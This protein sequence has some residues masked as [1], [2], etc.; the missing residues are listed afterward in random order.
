MPHWGQQSGDW[1]LF[2]RTLTASQIS[3]SPGHPSESAEQAE[4]ASQPIECTHLVQAEWERAGIPRSLV[5]ME[6]CVC[7]DELE[8]QA[9]SGRQASLVAFSATDSVRVPSMG[10]RHEN[11]TIPFEDSLAPGSHP[12]GLKLPGVL[13]PCT[14]NTHTC[15]HACAHTQLL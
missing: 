8:G 2:L 6:I 3:A 9:H 14:L 11:Q 1:V 12:Q 13:H 4:T 5:P 10:L 7:S 15:M